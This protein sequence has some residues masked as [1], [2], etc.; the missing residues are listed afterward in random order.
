V[1]DSYWS[2]NDGRGLEATWDDLLERIP[3]VDDAVFTPDE[4]RLVERS[5]SPFRDEAFAFGPDEI[6]GAGGFVS[7]LRFFP[8]FFFVV[9]SD[10]CCCV[11]DLVA[12][13][14]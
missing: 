3:P 1:L 4:G 7:L 13:L 5:R 2:P 9:V 10:D 14:I 8:N 6:G 11:D 12:E